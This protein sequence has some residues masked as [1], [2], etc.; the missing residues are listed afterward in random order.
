MLTNQSQEDRDHAVHINGVDV[1]SASSRGGKVRCSIANE[2][3]IIPF[4]LPLAIPY[5]K[6]S[7]EG[8]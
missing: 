1:K 5:S 8:P 6:I 7:Y 2:C 4:F 3:D